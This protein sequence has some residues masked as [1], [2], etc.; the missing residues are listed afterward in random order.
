V[1]LTNI[2]LDD[3]TEKGIRALVKDELVKVVVFAFWGSVWLC[4]STGYKSCKFHFPRK[5]A[6]YP[7]TLPSYIIWH[8]L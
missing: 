8:I 3:L 4:A 5:L 7:S 1:I 6:L 2:P